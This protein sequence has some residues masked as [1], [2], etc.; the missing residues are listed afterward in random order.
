D[1]PAVCFNTCDNC[2]PAP[3]IGCTNPN[4]SNYNSSAL[5]DDGSCLF[6]VIL[7]VNMNGTSW[8]QGD[9]VNVNGT[10]NSWCGACDPM[11]DPENDG[12]F[13]K[14][15][16]LPNGTHEYKFTTNGWNGLVEQFQVGEACTMSTFGNNETFTNRFFVVNNDAIDMDMVCFDECTLCPLAQPN[17]V[18]VKF[19]VDGFE[20]GSESFSVEYSQMGQG[21]T[22]DLDHVGWEIHEVTLSLL[23]DTPVEFRFIGDGVPEDPN[24]QCFL[25]SFRNYTPIEGGANEI[26][27]CFEECDLCPGCSDPL[28]ANFN[29]FSDG[30]ITCVGI[31]IFG[32]TYDSATNFDNSATT[33]D[34]SCEFDVA[35]NSCPGDLNQ[36]SVIN[37]ADLLSFLGQFGSTC[38]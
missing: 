5:V 19:S 21:G 22:I 23:A 7:N 14:S 2:E 4:A 27:V 1:G 28:A 18:T 15:L 16:F 3:N 29:P 20:N 8:Q 25:N 9:M 10:F 34:G 30:S 17:P 37:A 38:L 6:E 24:N 13:T 32:C 26:L 36:D 31:N 35:N 12:A 11:L 33:D